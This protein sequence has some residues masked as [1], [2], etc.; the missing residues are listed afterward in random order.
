M[1]DQ[2]VFGF[3]FAGVVFLALMICYKIILFFIHSEKTDKIY[4]LLMYPQVN[5]VF[6]DNNKKRRIKQRQ[7]RLSRYLLFFASVYLMLTSSVFYPDRIYF[8]ISHVFDQFINIQHSSSGIN[9]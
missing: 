1:L 2:I 4:Y 5:I 8:A 7:N 9:F 3:T 6:T